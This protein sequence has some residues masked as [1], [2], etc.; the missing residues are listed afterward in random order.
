MRCR[1][2]RTWVAFLVVGVASLAKG[3]TEVQRVISGPGG[4]D[5]CGAAFAGLGDVNDDGHDDYAVGCPDALAG[6]GRVRLVSGASGGNIWH[7]AGPV[8]ARS[9]GAA[10]A[11]IRD[12]N[13]DGIDELAVGAPDTDFFGVNAGAAYV[14]NGATG[15]VLRTIGGAAAG[16]R[17]GF[18]VAGF[19]MAGQ[20]NPMV[21]ASSPYKSSE[22]GGFAVY[23]AVTGALWANYTGISVGDH[24]GWSIAHAGDWNGDGFSDVVFGLPDRINPSG[25]IGEVRV[26]SIAL[27]AFYTLSILWP[28]SA[29]SG[30]GTSVDGNGNLNGDEFSDIVVGAPRNPVAGSADGGLVRTYTGPFGD[31]WSAVQGPAQT[32]TGTAVAFVGD[33]DGDGISDFAS[34]A[35]S[36]AIAGAPPARVRFRSGNSNLEIGLISD[37]SGTP[38]LGS[39]VAAAGDANRDGFPDLVAGHRSTNL[40][41]QFGLAP[42]WVGSREDLELRT[43]IEFGWYRSWPTEF[44]FNAAAIGTPFS[45]ELRSPGGTYSGALPFILGSFRPVNAAAYSLAGFPEVH[46]DPFS[47]SF[48][49]E[50]SDASFFAGPLLGSAGVQ[51]YGQ[52][53]PGLG[54]LALQIQG[55][56]LAPAPYLGNPNFTLT[57]SIALRFLN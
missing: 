6:V 24:A 30:F 44:T 51:V 23:D 3:Q 28:N 20:A 26:Q 34:G 36:Q 8:A 55:G 19:R 17:F 1:M 14:V 57:N 39:A 29:D 45:L 56:V 16:D 38:G 33:V 25:G 5:G 31:S 40:A 10:L 11:R 22:R 32:R 41:W 48:L 4:G 2:A 27:G 37:A 46:L 53:P 15:V 9:Y 52:V 47:V 43:S 21:A 54:G 50:P 49:Y 13:A 42:P 7:V 35:P 18:S 12:V